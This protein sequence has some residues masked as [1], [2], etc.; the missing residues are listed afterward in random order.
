MHGKI[1]SRHNFLGGATQ[2]VRKRNCAFD[3]AH[4]SLLVSVYTIRPSVTSTVDT[5]ITMHLT[6][7]VVV[8]LKYTGCSLSLFTTFAPFAECNE[9]FLVWRE[10][11]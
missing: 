3:M 9:Q 1:G 7:R 5:Y 6:R 4:S 2:S 8:T 10:A 11:A